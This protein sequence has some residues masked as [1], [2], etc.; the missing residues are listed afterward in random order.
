MSV[1][2]RLSLPH[3][4]IQKSDLPQTQSQTWRVIQPSIFHIRRLVMFFLIGLHL[5]LQFRL[6]AEHLSHASSIFVIVSVLKFTL[7]AVLELI[8]F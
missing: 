7:F 6:C 8:E 3:M 4:A 1:A 2:L 5:V